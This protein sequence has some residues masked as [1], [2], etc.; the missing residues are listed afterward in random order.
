MRGAGEC[1]GQKRELRGLAAELQRAGQPRFHQAPRQGA[2]AR[3]GDQVSGADE[4]MPDEWLPDVGLQQA[5]RGGEAGALGDAQ[6]A[7][8]LQQRR[9]GVAVAGQL[10]L[11]LRGRR[12]RA[13]ERRQRGGLA[14]AQLAQ[15]LVE[16]LPFSRAVLAQR[17]EDRHYRRRPMVASV[18]RENTQRWTANAAVQASATHCTQKR[19]GEKRRFSTAQVSRPEIIT[20]AWMVSR[21]R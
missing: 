12:Q 11:L 4:E 3:I 5:A 19:S 2:Q 8:V 14:V 18:P 7:G 10:L 15:V 21:A 20:S 16:A 13:A 6:V 1:A 9:A 17:R